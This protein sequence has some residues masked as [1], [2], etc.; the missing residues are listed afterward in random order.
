[1]KA[2]SGGRA[3]TSKNVQFNKNHKAEDIRLTNI[4]AAKCNSSKTYF[5]ILTQKFVIYSVGRCCEN[6]FGPKRHG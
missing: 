4:A 5:L 6:L 2:K 3:R 1:M